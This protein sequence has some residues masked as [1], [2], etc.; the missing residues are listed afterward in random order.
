VGATQQRVEVNANAVLV[1]TESAVKVVKALDGI[2]VALD[3]KLL[4]RAFSEE[5][6]SHIDVSRARRVLELASAL[7]AR[8]RVLPCLVKLLRHTD[9]RLQSKA[10]ALFCRAS[11]NPQW[12]R[13]KLSSIDARVRANAIEA[14]WGPDSA[15]FRELLAAASRDED[16][17]VAANA[18]VGL[19]CMGGQDSASAQLEKMAANPAPRFRSAAGFAMGQTL[20]PAFVPTLN[21]LLKDQD[22]AVRR[23]ALRGLIRIRK[24]EAERAAAGSAGTEA[25]DAVSNTSAPAGVAADGVSNALPGAVPADPPAAPVDGAP[26]DVPAAAAEASEEVEAGKV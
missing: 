24:A 10:T 20:D 15:S 17:R 2:E 9:P 22:A 19:H 3:V 1:D 6:E 26:R 25:L 16:H 8:R 23:Q 18:L 4:Q 12:V 13:E 21:T 11:R 14:L 7:P 5:A